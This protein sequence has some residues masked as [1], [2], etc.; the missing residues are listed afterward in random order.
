MT[1]LNREQW[2]FCLQLGLAMMA[3]YFV[4][5]GSDP[6]NA[7][8]AVLGAGLVTTPSVG[9]GLGVS[10]ERIVGTLLG[11]LVSLSAMWLHHP[12]LA[13]AVTVVVIGPLGMMLGGMAV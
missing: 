10:K 11:A 13:L 4:T 2:L 12:A 9:E 3:A 5:H 8:Y 6:T 1:L 7:I